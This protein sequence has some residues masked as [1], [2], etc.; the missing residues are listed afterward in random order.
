MTGGEVQISCDEEL[1]VHNS[2]GPRNK[3]GCIIYGFCIFMACSM[4]ESHSNFKWVLLAAK[5]VTF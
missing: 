3:K 4:Y 2:F 1:K 5:K